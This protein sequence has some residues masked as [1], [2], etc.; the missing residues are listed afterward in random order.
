MK[1]PFFTLL[2]TLLLIL[3][4]NDMFG[5]TVKIRAY[6]NLVSGDSI[7]GYILAQRYLFDKKKAH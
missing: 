2:L 1:K 7:K 6:L 4:S 3:L 5:Q